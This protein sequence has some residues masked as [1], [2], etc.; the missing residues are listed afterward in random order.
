MSFYVELSS[1]T[2][3]QYNTIGNFSNRVQ[4]LHPLDG[5]WEVAMTEIFYTKS[6]KNVAKNCAVTLEKMFETPKPAISYKPV[7]GYF[8]Q[9]DEERKGILR[10]GYYENIKDLCEE[11]EKEMLPFQKD[12]KFL[13]KFVFDKVTQNVLIKPGMNKRNTLMLPRLNHELAGIFG[14]DYYSTKHPKHNEDMLLVPDR[15]ADI[16]A[17]ITS[18]FVYCNLIVP[19]Y[20]GDT[21]AKLL[22]TVIVPRNKK[23]GETISVVYPTPNYVPVL[24]NDFESIEIDIKDDT[25]TPIY[26]MFG[27]TRVKLHF[28]KCQTHT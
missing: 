8:P 28:R 6:W 26:F 25:N 18:L 9:K 12:C 22:K 15:P 27:R 7:Y 5:D 19:Q 23:F 16:T 10:S 1:N 21:R 20:V 2:R 4:L 17:G 24:T 14:Y 11:I 13:P 3:Y